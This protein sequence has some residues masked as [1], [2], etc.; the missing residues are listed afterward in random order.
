[1]PE[2]EVRA[3]SLR[4]LV[5]VWAANPVAVEEAAVVDGEL[6]VPHVACAVEVGVERDLVRGPT[7]RH[8]SLGEEAEGDRGGSGGVDCQV[9]AAALYQGRPEGLRLTPD[10]GAVRPGAGLAGGG[11]G[12]HAGQHNSLRLLHGLGRC[13]DCAGLRADGHA[14]RQ[15]APQGGRIAAARAGDCARGEICGCWMSLHKEG[16]SPTRHRR[17]ARPRGCRGGHCRHTYRPGRHSG[18]LKHDCVFAGRG[19]PRAFPYLSLP[20][21]SRRR[22]EIRILIRLP[23]N[24]SVEWWMA[25]GRR[26]VRASKTS[27]AGSRI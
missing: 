19:V 23:Q 7:L 25:V 5:L 18:G 13:G 15:G 3:L 9:D 14:R 1:M 12:G 2:V 4:D 22:T 11:G 24:P 6:H 17:P 20:P 21:T 10:G 16:F 27:L 26:L 8:V